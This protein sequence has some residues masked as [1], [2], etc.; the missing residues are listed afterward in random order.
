MAL[1]DW[2]VLAHIVRPQGRHGEV[3]AEL[4]T[5]FPERFAERKRL[6]LLRG[7]AL[8]APASEASEARLESFRL[9]QGRVVLKLAGVD[10][11]E[12][13][14]ALRGYDV[15]IPVAERAP[16]DQDSVYI[17]DL[18][19]SELVDWASGG[20]VIGTIVDVDRQST[21]ASAL[22]VVRTGPGQPELLVPF[23]KAYLRRMELEN[24]RI[25]MELPAGLLDLNTSGTKS[26][27]QAKPAAEP[28]PAAA[29]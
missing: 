10:S 19:G 5:D 1:S 14:E 28:A 23:V 7:A 13:A 16:L 3:L 6:F 26:D 12:Q 29:Q 21:A 9:H 24:R 17:A 18:I 15:A 2:A 4:L 11:I 27:S 22:L 20:R 25:E 8:A